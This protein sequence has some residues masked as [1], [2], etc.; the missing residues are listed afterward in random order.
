MTHIAC[1]HRSRV[2]ISREFFG[3]TSVDG[4]HIGITFAHRG[5]FWA[6]KDLKEAITAIDGEKQHGRRSLACGRAR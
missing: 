1:T 5:I 4:H 6:W 3:V 2:T